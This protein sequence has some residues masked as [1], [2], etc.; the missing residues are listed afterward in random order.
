M[1][2]TKEISQEIE[3]AR[4]PFNQLFNLSQISGE[5]SL[6][7]PLQIV[8]RELSSYQK[9]LYFEGYWQISFSPAPHEISPWDLICC[10]LPIL[11]TS[12]PIR[13]Q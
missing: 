3:L 5:T 6:G 12:I 4:F 11:S 9:H 1:Q 10:R 7:L 13:F 2:M 8:R